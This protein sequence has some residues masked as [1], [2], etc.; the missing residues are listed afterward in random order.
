MI[1]DWLREYQYYSDNHD[2]QV[3][4]NPYLTRKYKLIRK[5]LRKNFMR[6]G[7]ELGRRIKT[8]P[9]IWYYRNFSFLAIVWVLCT[10][11]LYMILDSMKL[12]TGVLT[13]AISRFRAPTKVKEVDLIVWILYFPLAILMTYFVFKWWHKRF[14]T[15]IQTLADIRFLLTSDRR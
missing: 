13:P 1:E 5:T 4:I 8:L 12:E 3:V 2:D 7:D 9:H 10:C 11:A 6:G 15:M 14:V